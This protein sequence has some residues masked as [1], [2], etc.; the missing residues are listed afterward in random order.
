M[1]SIAPRL[2]LTEEMTKARHPLE[3]M[4]AP[5]RAAE[6]PYAR[7]TENSLLLTNFPQGV[8]VD[9][10]FIMD[11][12]LTHGDR[13]AIRQVYIKECLRGDEAE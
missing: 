3:Y 12:C 11:L 1:K 13:P 8:K 4:A 5:M 6:D 7:M 10:A 9:E 2:E